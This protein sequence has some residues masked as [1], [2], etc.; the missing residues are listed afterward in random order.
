MHAAAPAVQ[1]SWY[2]TGKA[3]AAARSP[4]GAKNSSIQGETVVHFTTHAAVGAGLGT[5]AAQVAPTPAGAVLAL[6]AGVVSHALLDAVP[7]KD[8]TSMTEVLVDLA[9]GVGITWWV[10][11]AKAAG[12]GLASPA[13][14]LPLLGALGGVLPDLEVA[15]V[16]LG[17][18]DRRRVIF[19]SHTGLTPHRLLPSGWGLVTQLPFIAAGLWLAF[20]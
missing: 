15:L 5:L 6:T 8:S 19:P 7:H 12:G 3:L 11:A 9:L 10:L 17:W 1:N 14:L 13:L 18:M 2:R 20:M 16:Y 4:G